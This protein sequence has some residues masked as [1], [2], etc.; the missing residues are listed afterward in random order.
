M[1]GLLRTLRWLL[2]GCRFN[3]PPAGVFKAQSRAFTH[4][5][6]LVRVFYA[7]NL[8]AAGWRL[9]E[10]EPW[11]VYESMYPLWPLFWAD[12]MKVETVAI[13]VFA[14]NA[15]F[16]ALAAIVPT[17]ALARWLAFAGAF[18]VGAF[19]NSFG[20]VGHAE[21]AWVWVSFFFAF[22]PAGSAERMAASRAAR[23]RFLLVFWAAQ[24]AMLFFYSMSGWLKLV[25]VPIQWHRGEVCSLGCEALARHIA[26]RALLT[27]SHP[28]L[29]DWMIDHLWLSWPLFLGAIYLE[30]F[31]VLAAFRPALHR[32]WGAGL[33]LLHLGI[34]LAMEIWFVPPMF[35]LALLLVNSPFHG[36]QVAWRE[37]IWQLP[38]L[39]LV[40]H[41]LEPARTLAPASLTPEYGAQRGP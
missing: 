21:H 34:G 31:A 26:N 35:L 12:G 36:E 28:P 17:S 22:L 10:R 1:T 7:A 37:A 5:L 14:A 23:Q 8:L 27:K 25:A 9:A 38:G 16:A 13:G 6:L 39:E 19:V 18:A 29:A 32:I 30:A 11:N 3:R 33:V 2:G 40:R 41:A 24:F 20:R 4:A 15:V